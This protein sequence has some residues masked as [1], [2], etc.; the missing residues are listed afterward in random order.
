[1]LWK[2][3]QYNFPIG[4][5]KATCWI[6]RR[7]RKAAPQTSFVNMQPNKKARKRGGKTG[8]LTSKETKERAPHN[9]YATTLEQEEA[10]SQGTTRHRMLG[11]LAK[12]ANGRKTQGHFALTPPAKENRKLH[13]KNCREHR[14]VPHG[15]STIAAP[16]T[17]HK[18][19]PRGF[20]YGGRN[21]HFSPISLDRKT[22]PPVNLVYRGNPLQHPLLLGKMHQVRN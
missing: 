10:P 14:P 11:S 18:R 19:N 22:L 4:R 12:P 17:L 3:T 21:R 1:M 15:S 13:G 6:F 5:K 9:R 8:N 16:K 20:T 7:T 2:L